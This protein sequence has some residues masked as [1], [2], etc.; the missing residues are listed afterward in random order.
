MSPLISI[1]PSVISVVVLI[2][3]G[4]IGYGKLVQKIDSLSKDID[5]VRKEIDNVR[6][7]VDN[8][9]RDVDNVRKEVAELRQYH[10]SHLE[11][12]PM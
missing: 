4:A 9:R 11:N 12:H 8:V 10:V 7:D 6:K 3:T 1:V 5:N 2:T